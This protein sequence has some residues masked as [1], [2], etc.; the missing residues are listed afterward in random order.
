MK[1]GT[2]LE[3]T[4]IS[5]NKIDLYINGVEETLPYIWK[6]D[7]VPQTIGIGE[8]YCVVMSNADI[9]AI[10]DY[11]IIHLPNAD[12]GHIAITE[13]R[14]PM[15]FEKASWLWDAHC[16][17]LHMKMVILFVKTEKEDAS[18]RDIYLL[19]NN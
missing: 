7:T 11:F 4:I 5:R 19:S 12:D 10:D 1:Y 16:F 6:D 15:L 17:K 3:A 9:E 13:Y 14:K 18:I 2:L 8:Y